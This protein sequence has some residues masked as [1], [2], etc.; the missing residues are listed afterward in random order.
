M[1]NQSLYQIQT[2]QVSG[3]ALCEKQKQVFIDSVTTLNTKVEKA[4]C[5]NLYQ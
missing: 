5:L 4:T 3:I 1:G 2:I